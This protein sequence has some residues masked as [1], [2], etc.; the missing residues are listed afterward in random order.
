MKS[1]AI[2][3]T[4]DEY[5]IVCQHQTIAGF[6]IA[7]E[8]MKRLDKDL[9]LEVIG[10]AVLDTLDSSIDNVPMPLDLKGV[11]QSLIKFAGVKSWKTLAK[12]AIYCGVEVASNE[13]VITPF[14]RDSHNA[15]SPLDS[16]RVEVSMDAIAVGKGLVEAS[17]LAF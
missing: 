9:P 10:S 2:Y 13:V 12:N 8:P 17:N 1:C 4:K 3:V 16:K 14:E 6:H 15:Y 11:T 5:L 7:G